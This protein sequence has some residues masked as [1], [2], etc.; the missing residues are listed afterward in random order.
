MGRGLRS[1]FVRIRIYRIGWIFRIPPLPNP[2]FRITE[3]PAKRNIDK[4]SPVEDARG[5]NPE[6]PLIPQI[7]ILTNTRRPLDSRPRFREGDVLSRE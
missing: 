7:L 1:V 2:R 5:E 4:R 3:N 6:N